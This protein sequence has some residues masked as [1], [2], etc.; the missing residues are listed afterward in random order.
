MTYT[1]EQKKR[2]YDSLPSDLKEAIISVDKFE[3]IQQISEK[4]SLMLDQAGELGDEINL[5]MLGLTKQD[6]FVNN[7]SKRLEISSSKS[8]E[9]SK[10]INTEILDSVRDSLQHIQ[11][12]KNEEVDN[13]SESIPDQVPPHEPTPTTY[14]SP[15]EKAGRFEIINNKPTSFSPQYKDSNLNKDQVLKDIENPPSKVSFVDHLLAN[16]A[17]PP[18]PPTPEPPK[19]TPAMDPYREPI[20]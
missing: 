12:Q 1:K 8:V 2:I 9:I 5:F 18:K 6:D 3:K 4:H 14:S 15:L 11:S 19:K 13:E 17:T 16:P 10:D 20:E 7:I